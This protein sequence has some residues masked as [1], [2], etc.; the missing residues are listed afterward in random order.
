M[1][2]FKAF[3]F[4]SLQVHIKHSKVE[5]NFILQTKK[6]TESQIKLD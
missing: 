3:A 1:L 5:I 4:L 6:A 2:H